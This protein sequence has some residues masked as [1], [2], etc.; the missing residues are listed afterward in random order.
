LPR[1]GCFGGV[2]LWQTKERKTAACRLPSSLPL[3]F[4]RQLVEKLLECLF[5]RQFGGE[6]GFEPIL[7]EPNFKRFWS[8]LYLP[9]PQ[10]RS[11]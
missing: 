2:F 5:A 3:F 7:V 6:R 11:A 1:K 8:A 10:R 4:F 9:R